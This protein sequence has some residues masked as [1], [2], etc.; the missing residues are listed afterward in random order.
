MAFCDSCGKDIGK[1]TGR[2]GGKLISGGSYDF[3]ESVVNFPFCCNYCGGTYC[4]EH[5]LP[6]KHN[7]QVDWGHYRHPGTYQI[8]SL[9]SQHSAITNS[10]RMVEG[11]SK[12][13]LKGSAEPPHETIAEQKARIERER[14]EL[15]PERYKEKVSIWKRLFGW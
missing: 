7:C 2:R 8:P 11:K 15:Y 4:S 12:G 10:G 6:E 13:H 1:D 14:R 5:R 3:N 9:K